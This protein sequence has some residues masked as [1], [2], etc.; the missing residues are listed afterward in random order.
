MLGI[1]WFA[2]LLSPSTHLERCE[3]GPASLCSLQGACVPVMHEP[4]RD[5]FGVPSSNFSA[6]VSL[7]IVPGFTYA[8]VCTQ[9]CRSGTQ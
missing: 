3:A 7:L 2:A 1:D 8:A 9:L 4:E 6:Q 5:A